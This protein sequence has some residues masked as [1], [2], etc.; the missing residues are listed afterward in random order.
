V[1]GRGVACSVREHLSLAALPLA[2][3]VETDFI[4]FALTLASVSSVSSS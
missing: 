4:W 3:G 2:A 1:C